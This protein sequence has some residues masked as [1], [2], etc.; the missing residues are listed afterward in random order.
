[1]NPHNNHSNIPGLSTQQHNSLDKHRNIV[2]GALKWQKHAPAK[3]DINEQKSVSVTRLR[4][5]FA[6]IL[7]IFIK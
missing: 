6:T 7:N 2:N 4:L 3:Q 5:A 1:M